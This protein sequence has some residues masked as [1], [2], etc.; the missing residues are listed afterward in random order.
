MPWI[1]PTLPVLGLIAM[2]MSLSYLM[3]LAVSLATGDGTALTFATAL[4][5]NFVSGL[6]LW[7][8][9][10]RH[11]RELQLREGILFIALVWIGGALFACP[12]L[13]VAL[14]LTFTDGY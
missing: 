2:A 5:L 8:A 13:I 4:A 10:R 7:F 6:L 1:F 3:R 9:T 14:G 11:R 12:P